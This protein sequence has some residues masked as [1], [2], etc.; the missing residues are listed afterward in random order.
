[1]RAT[2][3]M[4]S[5]ADAAE[6]VALSSDSMNEEIDEAE[7]FRRSQSIES[8][9]S[10]TAEFPLAPELYWVK[11]LLVALGRHLKIGKLPVIQ[12]ASACTGTCA[13]ASVFKD[14]LRVPGVLE[15]VRYDYDYDY[16]HDASHNSQVIT[17][18][19]SWYDHDASHNS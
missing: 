7:C 10:S 12:V 6:S 5:W 8:V 1:M 18:N 11:P 4:S 14:R 19:N 16:D 13:E 15:K 3:K 9:S 2:P 17:H